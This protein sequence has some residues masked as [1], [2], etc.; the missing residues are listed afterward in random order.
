MSRFLRVLLCTAILT[1]GAGV[2]SAHHVKCSRDINN[3]GKDNRKDMKII[4]DAFGSKVGVGPY[5]E[6]ADLDRDGM[7]NES[8]REAYLHCT[9]SAL[10]RDRNRRK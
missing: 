4:E 9:P 6:R 3:D 10:M 7:V 5:D 1:L 8:D 2:A